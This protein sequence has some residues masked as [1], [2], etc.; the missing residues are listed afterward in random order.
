MQES[1]SRWQVTWVFL[2]KYLGII[3]TFF[4]SVV[5]TASYF[6]QHRPP[7]YRASATVLIERPAPPQASG[8][9][10]P[11]SPHPS[12][13]SQ[14]HYY[15]T[16][17]EIL[18]SRSLASQV[19]QEHRLQSIFAA[20]SPQSGDR[21]TQEVPTDWTQSYLLMLRIEPVDE[22]HL[23]HITFH[24]AD[25]DL[26]ARLAN[27]HAQTYTQ[28]IASLGSM[29]QHVDVLDWAEV[30]SQPTPPQAGMQLL[31]SALVGLLGGVGFAW[32]IEQ[33]DNTFRTP[34]EIQRDLD[35][36][37]LSTVPN[38]LSLLPASRKRAQ[39]ASAGKLVHL[40][41]A[42]SHL[43]H[44]AV[45]EIYAKLCTAILLS[46]P[47]ATPKKILFTSAL[48]EEGKTTNVVNT[49]IML[50][51]SGAK[52]LLIDA[53]VRHPSCH[54]ILGV[55]NPFGLTEVITG[56]HQAEHVIQPTTVHNLSLL[57]AGATP[58]NPTVLLGSTKLHDTL[59]ALQMHYDCICIDSPPVLP[60]SD[61]ELLATMVQGVVL[62]IDEQTT[63]KQLAKE[64][65]ARLTH[66]R[67]NL[68]GIVL[69]RATPKRLDYAYYHHIPLSNG[70]GHR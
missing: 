29:A 54:K 32:L 15:R 28:R 51:L 44:A 56:Q 3:T 2:C 50:A 13:A 22:T 57:T 24:A 23:V 69:N 65:R 59:M 36:P 1:V 21:E 26:A 19:I 61:A 27:A 68:L 52:V 35:L 30:P 18:K 7:I 66:A 60:V 45:A 20:S 38:F 37:I 43:S 70:Y 4:L 34:E 33:F 55:A 9:N 17:Y 6:A 25:P 12:D 31:L 53:D 10:M 58:P 40:S 11:S 39:P 49:A 14:R 8:G 62:V 64:T 48:A 67:A 5:L 16:Q 63:P 41:L 42:L 47:G 46:Q